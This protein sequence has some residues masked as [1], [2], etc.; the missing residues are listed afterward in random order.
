MTFGFERNAHPLVGKLLLATPTLRDPNFERAVVLVVAHSEDGALGVV[1]NRATEL[2]TSDLLAEWSGVFVSPSVVFEGGP[3]QPEAAICLA[4][5]RPDA[6]PLGFSPIQDGSAGVIGTL[7]LT[8]APDMLADQISGARVFAGYAGWSSEQLRDEI[9]EGAWFVFDALP[10]DIFAPQP[11]DLWSSVLQ[12]QGGL[13]AA[14]AKFPE[15]PS[16]N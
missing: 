2:A 16:L 3:V 9:E 12:R 11:D 1:L 14:V 5:V 10:S 6:E 15:N 7:D 4:R 13:L 8:L